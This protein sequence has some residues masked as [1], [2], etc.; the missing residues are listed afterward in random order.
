M[1]NPKRDYGHYNPNN[2]DWL[3]VE[4]A[5]NGTRMRLNPDERV[6]VVARIGSRVPAADLAARIGCGDKEVGLIMAALD[7]TARCPVCRHHAFHDEA[8]VLQ[9][10]LGVQLIWPCP[11]TGYR[12][13]SAADHDEYRRVQR[14]LMRDIA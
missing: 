1:P 14:A 11:F 9:P 3:A 10:H 2:I 6:A 13:D 4:F 8:G 5:C 7:N 12:Y